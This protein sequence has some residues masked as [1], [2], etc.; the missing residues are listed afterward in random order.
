MINVNFHKLNSIPDDKLIYA[1]ICTKH[2]NLW[3]WCK[4]KKRDTWEIPGG[5]RE[6]GEDI[7][8]TARRELFEETG[9]SE[10]ELTAVSEYSVT[11]DGQTKFG[12]LFFAAVL[13]FKQ[14]QM[15]DEIQE[16]KGFS[17]LP[18]ALSFTQIQ[19]LLLKY[20]TKWKM[21]QFNNHETNFSIDT[22][23]N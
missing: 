2:D 4:N 21:S 5:K 7:E 6:S 19:P 12:R 17:E 1:V 16:I 3:I 8:K 14:I 22:N 13:V 11:I 18:P 20:V 15:T 9:A 10:F 23:E